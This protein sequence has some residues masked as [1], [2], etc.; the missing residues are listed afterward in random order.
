MLQNKWMKKEEWKMNNLT[1]GKIKSEV[2]Q[3]NY[4]LTEKVIDK[5]IY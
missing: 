3:K 4:N 2:L 1:L 5:F